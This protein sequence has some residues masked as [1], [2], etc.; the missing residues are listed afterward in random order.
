MALTLNE[1]VDLVSEEALPFFSRVRS[2]A[3]PRHL[4]I[5]HFDALLEVSDDGALSAVSAVAGEGFAVKEPP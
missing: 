3:P 1:W 4:G 2:R 5:P